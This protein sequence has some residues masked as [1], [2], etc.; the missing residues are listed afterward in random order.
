[1][2]ATEGQRCEVKMSGESET[3]RKR[4]EVRH[5]LRLLVQESKRQGC[6]EVVC[7][8]PEVFAAFALLDPVIGEAVEQGSVTLDD[9]V[10]WLAV[11]L[12]QG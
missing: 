2:V 3:A 12:T 7:R 5:V 9:L 10:V 11:L 8:F 1:M 6:F 4:A